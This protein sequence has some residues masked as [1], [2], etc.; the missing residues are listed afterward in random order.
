MRYIL[1]TSQI[2]EG[3]KFENIQSV[4]EGGFP[5]CMMGAI[6]TTVWKGN[7]AT[8]PIRMHIPFYQ[9][10]PLLESF[11][12]QIQFHIYTSTNTLSEQTLKKKGGSIYS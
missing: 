10:I 12:K 11:P 2:R 1:F 9:A 5:T 7:L 6:N 8:Y 4:K 3:K